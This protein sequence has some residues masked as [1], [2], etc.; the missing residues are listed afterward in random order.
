MGNHAQPLKVGGEEARPSR[1]AVA[2]EPPP[3]ENLPAD[4]IEW[5][6]PLL[7]CGMGKGTNG[8]GQKRATEMTCSVVLF[9]CNL[10]RVR[11]TGANI[12]AEGEGGDITRNP[13]TSA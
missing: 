10:P 11:G 5:V 8:L 13:S 4:R 7:Q 9:G 2:S 12:M 1:C 6:R 3:D